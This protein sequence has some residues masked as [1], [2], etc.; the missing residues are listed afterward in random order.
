MPG[1]ESVHHLAPLASAF[2]EVE[3]VD[4]PGVIV[5]HI[6]AHKFSICACVQRVAKRVPR[7]LSVILEQ[8]H[9]IPVDHDS[10]CAL[11]VQA[12]ATLGHCPRNHETKCVVCDVPSKTCS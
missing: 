1:L 11:V 5:A 2:G 12:I 8:I 7:G 3:Q 4:T 6:G 10:D 9:V